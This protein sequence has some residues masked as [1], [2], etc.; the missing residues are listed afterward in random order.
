MYTRKEVSFGFSEAYG[1]KPVYDKPDNLLHR[2]T[3]YY[4]WWAGGQV[5]VCL[6]HTVFSVSQ[7]YIDLASAITAILSEQSALSDNG[8]N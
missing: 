5:D 1:C 7:Y 3:Y 8:A 6:M 2:K 4:V